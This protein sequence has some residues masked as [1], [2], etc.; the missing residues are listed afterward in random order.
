[1]F[2][3][4]GDWSELQCT[5]IAYAFPGSGASFEVEREP[6]PP[7]VG[8]VAAAERRKRSATLTM[9]RDRSFSSL[10]RWNGILFHK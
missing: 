5:E 10:A 8:R 1:M 6:S 3:V 2:R 4:P 7:G 9:R